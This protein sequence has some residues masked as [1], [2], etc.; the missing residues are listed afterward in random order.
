MK[1][2]LNLE[3]QQKLAAKLLKVDIS[4]VERVGFLMPETDILI[5][6]LTDDY[7]EIGKGYKG[8]VRL[9]VDK[10]GEVLF[11]VSSALSNDKMLKSF[12]EG[13]RTP[14]SAFER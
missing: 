3:D 10:N 4:L 6:M 13:K 12:Y 1:K 5:V 8:G 7:K 2:Y 11:S 9:L 14:L